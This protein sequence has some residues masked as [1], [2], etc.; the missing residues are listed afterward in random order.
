MRLNWGLDEF[1]ASICCLTSFPCLFVCFYVLHQGINKLLTFQKMSSYPLIKIKILASKSSGMIKLYQQIASI[2][3]H[4]LVPVALLSM[5]YQ[6][7]ENLKF[8][9]RMQ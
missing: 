8:F 2:D 3:L 9:P 4:V 5:K 1:G 6:P 7:N